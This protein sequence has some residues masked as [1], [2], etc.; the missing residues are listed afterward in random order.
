MAQNRNLLQSLERM[1]NAQC[2]QMHVISKK[3][4]DLHVR[5]DS[6]QRQ[7]YLH[8][9]P[10]PRQGKEIKRT[11]SVAAWLFEEINYLNSNISSGEQ[12]YLQFPDNISHRRLN[13]DCIRELEGILSYHI[14]DLCGEVTWEEACNLKPKECESVIR[15]AR[16]LPELAVFAQAAGQWALRMLCANKMRSKL[17]TKVGKR[18]AAS[19]EVAYDNAENALDDRRVQGM[20]EPQ[21]EGIQRDGIEPE[22]C[23]EIAGDA[24]CT[25][26]RNDAED[27]LNEEH[28]VPHHHDDGIQPCLAEKNTLDNFCGNV[29]K[30][31]PEDRNPQQEELAL[32]ERISDEEDQVMDLIES[33]GELHEPRAF[34]NFDQSELQAVAQAAAA[35]ALSYASNRN[36]SHQVA[37]KKPLETQIAHTRTEPINVFPIR[38]TIERPMLKVSGDSEKNTAT[39]HVRAR[40]QPDKNR[41]EPKATVALDENGTVPVLRAQSKGVAAQRTQKIRPVIGRRTVSLRRGVTEKTTNSRTRGGAKANAATS[42]PVPANN[43]HRNTENVHRSL[44][45]NLSG[46]H[47]VGTVS[48]TNMT[49]KNARGLA[50]GNRGGASSVHKGGGQNTAKTVMR[51]NVRNPGSAKAAAFQ[52]SRASAKK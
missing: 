15:E 12:K 34:S 28:H 36:P 29:D 27:V 35:H 33:D 6:L 23:S 41:M 30:G 19:D 21:M 44:F 39:N 2:R 4:D 51:K 13:N 38:R 26:E 45:R 24:R 50:R 48:G 1:A 49:N 8:P 14:P 47:A 32:Q 37:F 3:I 11:T 25:E 17:A 40:I 10:K 18:A 22:F 42:T 43:S 7:T 52:R 9:I 31:I 16:N 20:N 5:M 46:R